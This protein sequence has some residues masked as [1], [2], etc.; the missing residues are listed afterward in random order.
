MDGSSGVAYQPVAD[1]EEDVN[2][3]EEDA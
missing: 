2:E 3:E 1:P